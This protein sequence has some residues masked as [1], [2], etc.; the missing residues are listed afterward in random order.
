[1]LYW[2]YPTLN[3]YHASRR[4]CLTLTSSIIP[5]TET[6]VTGYAL[7]LVNC[8]WTLHEIG[9]AT[10]R[11]SDCFF[12]ALGLEEEAPWKRTGPGN[13]YPRACL[14]DTSVLWHPGIFFGRMHG[15][16][17]VMVDLVQLHLPSS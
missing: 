2:C 13:P 5:C 17:T 9:S 14:R 6:R 12:G 4:L 1:M 3:I 10:S 16:S 15:A 7:G 11:L 8:L